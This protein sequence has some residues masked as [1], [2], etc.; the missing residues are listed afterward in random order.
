VSQRTTRITLLVSSAGRRVELIN[1]FRA[2]AEMLG[3]NLR[4]LAADAAPELSPAC[5]LADAAVRAPS[6]HHD[7]FLPFIEEL[8]VREAVSL[9]VPTIDPELE[10]Y[11]GGAARL[12]SLG[13][14]VNIS[15]PEVVA[16]ARNKLRTATTLARH[17]VR[18]PRTASLVAALREQAAWQGGLIIKPVDGSSSIGVRRLD[19]ITNLA[20]WPDA[21]RYVVQE[22]VR[23]QEYTVN[24][25]CDGNG[26]LCCAVPHRRIAIRGGEVSKGKTERIDALAQM[27]DQIV[28]AL[29]G[30]RGAMCFQAIVDQ[31][32]AA[33]LIE[34][35]ARFGGG[36]PLAHAA[37]ARF[38]RWLLE[39]VLGR[40]STA[41][42]EWREALTMLRYDSSV[43]C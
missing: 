16:V 3:V 6:C 34:I 20:E 32:G 42:D 10:V 40:A 22:F 11:A 27:A 35:N 17:G 12:L 43:F 28:V 9:I 1:C 30:C 39:E 37:G 26:R 5:K 21:G 8:V 19:S 23:G 36:F 14:V 15:R 38:P 29:V 33:T 24:M 13:A 2:D 4:V 41:G 7:E 31:A 25:Y 18:V